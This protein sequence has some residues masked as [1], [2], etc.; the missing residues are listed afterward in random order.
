M[1][2]TVYS[3]SVVNSV[4]DY[5]RNNASQN[6]RD[7]VPPVDSLNSAAAIGDIIMD[8]PVLRNE[9]LNALVQ[10]FAM[11]RIMQ[12]IFEDPFAV[13]TNKGDLR[14][15]GGVEQIFVDLATPYQYDEAFAENKVDA[16]FDPIIRAAYF[17]INY[18]IVYPVSISYDLIRDSFTSDEGMATLI[19]AVV[20]STWEGAKQ[21]IYETYK[22][23]LAK[24][25]LFGRM[26]A[27]K[28]SNDIKETAGIIRGIS[29][30]F[31]FRNRDYN[32]AGVAKLT[33]RDDQFLLLNTRFDGLF[34]VE[35][36][37]T[38]FNMD[39]ADFL[40]HRIIYDAFSNINF[41]RLGVILAD[42]P[43]YEPFTEAQLE[44]LDNIPG[45]IVSRDF[46]QVYNVLDE[47]RT[48][49]QE[50][51]L[52]NSYYLHTWRVMATSPF[53]Q[54]V[55]LTSG[56]PSVESIEVTP[57]S[58]TV[59][60][61]QQIQLSARV[62]TQNFAPKT[63]NWTIEGSVLQGI[64]L[65]RFG[66]LKTTSEATAGEY[67]VTATSVFDGEVSGTAT[68]TIANS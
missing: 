11:T 46:F 50:L 1:S 55:I 14:H 66:L 40:G 27:I 13:F 28:I 15:G 26:E 37:S 18:K 24:N 8:T 52:W 44:A 6:Y 22:Y 45:F 62:N 63:V 2:K 65:T 25:A 57:S 43:D 53:A 35:V 61:G 17:V 29:N 47:M 23:M 68:I 3:S 59:T 64:E 4:L 56:E 31:T 30:N 48:R 16:R 21:D 58:A 41:A 5:I 32:P 10:K 36:L 7:Y 60:A 34:D 12:D 54:S 49:E 9:Y 67:T 19:D 42:D 51:G 33:K 38:A 39:K 20:Q